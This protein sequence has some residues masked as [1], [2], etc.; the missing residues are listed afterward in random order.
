FTSFADIENWLQTWVAS[1]DE[2]FLRDGIRKLPEKWE[3]VVASDGKYF[4]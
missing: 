2:S 4:N 1:K 3:K